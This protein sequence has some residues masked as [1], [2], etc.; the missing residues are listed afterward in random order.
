[1]SQYI[2]PV[3][4]EKDAEAGPA[5]HPTHLEKEAPLKRAQDVESAL[6]P[7]QGFEAP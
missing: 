7:E 6:R 4:P 5:S 2:K 1:M 3:E